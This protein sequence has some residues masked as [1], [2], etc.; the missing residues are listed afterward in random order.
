VWS[1]LNIRPSENLE[2]A[3]RI[4]NTGMMSPQNEV[5]SLSTTSIMVGATLAALNNGGSP[6][7]ALTVPVLMN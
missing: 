7:A 6:L 1:S 2:L 4:K 3:L 5:I